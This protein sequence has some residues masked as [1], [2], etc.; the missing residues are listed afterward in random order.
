MIAVA[1]VVVVIVVGVGV[2]VCRREVGL[3]VAVGP[4]QCRSPSR[5]ALESRRRVTFLLGI[6]CPISGQPTASL[7][8]VARPCRSPFAPH[9][10]H[11]CRPYTHCF[12]VGLFQS[13]LALFPLSASY[14]LVL[15]AS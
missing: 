1:A 4:W 5:D 12:I 15:S 10:S 8:T 2:V 6:P 13:L 14:R 3:V 9:T 7:D 11:S